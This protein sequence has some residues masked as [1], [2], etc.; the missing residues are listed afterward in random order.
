MK[1]LNSLLGRKDLGGESY[2]TRRVTLENPLIIQDPKIGFLNLMGALARPLIKE[3]ANALKSMFSGCMESDGDI[4][5]CDVLMIYATID[6]SGT[7]QNIP[8]SLREIIYKSHAPI[9]VVA[10]ENDVQ[11]YIAA[12]KRSG[13]GRANLVMTLSR[14][15]QMFPNFFRELFAMMHRG[16]TMPMAW[17]KLAP[18]IPGKDRPNVPGTMCAMEV[19]HV[20]FKSGADLAR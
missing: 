4:P 8:F 11:S 12:G 7:I 2:T 17:V 15:G 20:L 1:W 18:Q 9:A 6:P 16:V 13:V 10:T 19:T 3:D 14:K 5:V